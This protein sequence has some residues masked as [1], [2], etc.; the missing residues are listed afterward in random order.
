MVQHAT[1]GYSYEDLEWLRDELGLAHLEFDPWGSVV[2]TP[3]ADEH[4]T[5]MVMLHDQAVAQLGL[6][7]GCVRPNAFGWKT[8]GGSGYTNVP[9]LIV[10]RPGW[11]R[12]GDWHVEPPPLLV[13]EVAS[14]SSVRIDRARKLDDYRLGGAGLYVRVDFFGP[15]QAGFEVYDFAAD[16]IRVA[17]GAVDLTV[18]GR[19]LRLDLTALAGGPAR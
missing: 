17:T 13:A 19:P 7:S 6:P 5:A 12:V 16:E 2:V 10:L 3:A 4:D 9:D 18:D 14:P 11:R 1:S 8:P 15:G